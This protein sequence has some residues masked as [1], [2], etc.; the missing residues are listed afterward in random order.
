MAVFIYDG[1]G[2]GIAVIRDNV[3]HS[4]A[5]QPIGQVRGT[6]VYRL[7]GEYVGD[8]YQDMVVQPRGASPGNVGRLPGM[9][10]SLPPMSPPPVRGVPRHP[11]SD[12][13][14]LLLAK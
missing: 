8:L 1:N 7:A 11:F 5:G 14:K 4:L 6:H 3:V 12:R 9:P 13:S 2:R 10:R